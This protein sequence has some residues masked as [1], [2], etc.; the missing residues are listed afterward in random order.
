MPNSLS[1]LQLLYHIFLALEISVHKFS[2]IMSHH[3]LTSFESLETI[4]MQGY[5]I[6]SVRI[7]STFLAICSQILEILSFINCDGRIEMLLLLFLLNRISTGDGMAL[8]KIGGV[9]C[10]CSRK[11]HGLPCRLLFYQV[12]GDF[13]SANP[14]DYG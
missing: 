2:V 7:L 10:S 11:Y 8:D 14:F 3:N 5:F 13:N 12:F 6:S 9:L 4:A 1:W